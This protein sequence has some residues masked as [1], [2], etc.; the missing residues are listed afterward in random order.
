MLQGPL[1]LQ[2]VGRDARGEPG[3]RAAAARRLEFGP[4][5]RAERWFVVCGLEVCDELVARRV[6]IF[7]V[8]RTAD[9]VELAPHLNSDAVAERVRL[10]HRMRRQEHR[11]PRHR[12]L[13]Q[14]P[15]V[16][17]RDGVQARGRFVQ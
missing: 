13:D 10:E 15:E 9:A 2:L 11:P 3:E 8:L 12:R 5:I 1:A 16:P 14:V 17:L 7:Q 6:P 4:E